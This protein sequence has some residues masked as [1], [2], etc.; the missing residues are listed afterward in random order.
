MIFA[1]G[2]K[3]ETL[4]IIIAIAVAAIVGVVVLIICYHHFLRVNINEERVGRSHILLTP[5]FNGN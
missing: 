2:T 4:W 3:S 1:A 5:S